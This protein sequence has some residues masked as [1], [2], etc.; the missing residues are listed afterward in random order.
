MVSVL[1]LIDI[2]RVN[3]VPSG[4]K[5]FPVKKNSGIQFYFMSR[6]REKRLSLQF[7]PQ[8]V[9]T[10]ILTCDW[11]NAQQQTVLLTVWGQKLSTVCL[12]NFV[13]QWWN[14][15]Q[16]NASILDI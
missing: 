9:S 14:F 15:P 8:S 12:M 2:H 10:T 1:W 4:I 3:P 16:A 7:L 13:F 5:T 6:S 11:S